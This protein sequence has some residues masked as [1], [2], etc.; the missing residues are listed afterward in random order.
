MQIAFWRSPAY[1]LVGTI[2]IVLISFGVR[3]SFGLF[4]ATLSADLGWGREVFSF[5]IAIQNLIIGLAAPLVAATAD[6]WGP[7]RVIALAGA[8]YTGGLFVMS[9]ATTPTMM[10]LSAGG[11]VGLG[12]S[13]CGLALL[14]ALA[15]RVAP[16]GKRSLW[17]GMVTAGGTA[18][19]LVVVPTSQQLL[20]AF[21]WV[22]ATVILACLT[23]AIP[24]LALSLKP[25]TAE[26]LSR[27]TQQSLT[28]ALREAG[29]HRGYWLLVGGFFVCGFQVQFVATHLPAYLT[30]SGADPA[31]G[32]TAIAVI[33]LF[34]MLGAWAAGWLGDRFRKKYL[35]CLLYGARALTILVF[36]QCPVTQTS[37]I[38]FAAVMGLLWLSTAPLT[39]GIVAQMFGTR[40]MGTLFAIVYMSH[41]L[42]S[43]T[44]VWLGGK[45]YDVT[46]S[47]EMFWWLAIALGLIAALIHY[48]INDR[49]TSRLAEGT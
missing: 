29:G 30:D 45:I 36:I 27:K 16:E 41:Q 44:G 18:G 9:Q 38:L 49:P 23:V 4:M 3:Q 48:P 2:L 10:I 28:D 7:I 14:L 35:L 11:L 31:L 42:G 6:K 17:L 1:V 46:G 34:N 15:G 25:G 39:S 8:V 12:V 33:G 47:Y 13:G 19:Q 20:G 43:F 32:A 26:A 24:F 37:V 40:Y 21:G 22:E 5:A